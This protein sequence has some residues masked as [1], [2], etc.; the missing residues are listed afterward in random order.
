MSKLSQVEAPQNLLPPSE[1]KPSSSS[2]TIW[3]RMCSA[4][5]SIGFCVLRRVPPHRVILRHAGP[6]FLMYGNVITG[7]VFKLRKEPNLSWRSYTEILRRKGEIEAYQAF[8]EF[9]YTISKKIGRQRYRPGLIWF[10]WF[11]LVREE[12][13]PE[14]EP[15]EKRL[16]GRDNPYWHL[17]Y[18]TSGEPPTAVRIR[19]AEIAT[20]RVLARCFAV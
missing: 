20:N 15:E 1:P 19:L 18:E 7:D 8:H 11:E 14:W 4:L 5:G 16:N 9:P 3:T 12:L 10:R 17:H 2:R 6:K 13:R